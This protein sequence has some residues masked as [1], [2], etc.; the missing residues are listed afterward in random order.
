MTAVEPRYVCN[1]SMSR[2]RILVE[3]VK[4][5]RMMQIRTNNKPTSMQYIERS[6]SQI[7]F[8]LLLHGCFCFDYDSSHQILCYNLT[9]NTLCRGEKDQCEYPQGVSSAVEG[10]RSEAVYAFMYRSH[11]NFPKRSCVH[12]QNL[13][14]KVSPVPVGVYPIALCNLSEFISMAATLLAQE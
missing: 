8:D 11:V 10:I 6:H 3:P 1:W 7:P 5:N 4:A 12:G 9:S 14:A 2:Y 13:G